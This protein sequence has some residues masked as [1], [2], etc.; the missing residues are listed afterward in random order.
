MRKLVPTFIPHRYR[1]A[2]RAV[3]FAV[4]S[5]LFVGSRYECP[6][7]GRGSRGWVSLGF[8][9]LVCPHC[10]AFERQRLLLL[11]L[12][13]ELEI[14]TRPLTMLHFAPERCLMRSFE[15]FP[16]LTYIGGDLDPPRGAVK[17]DIT[18]IELGSDTVDV[19]ICSHV[20]E[21]VSEDAQAMREMR[22]VLRPGGS[23]LIMGPVD[24]D[25]PQTYEDP[26]IVNPRARVAAF[27]QS[28]HV[29]LYGAD[30]DQ[31]LRA[32]GF[33]VDANR[34]AEQL[35]SDEVVRHG[36]DRHEIIYVCT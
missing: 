5:V 27:G 24:Y 8:P 1:N 30:F 14:A 11:Y 33:E 19:V 18:N 31:R 3:V 15:R 20:L 13:N 22:R 12:R 17:L 26:T 23:A 35:P 6:V 10:S 4:L 25:R 7:C 2:A 16:N 9:N 29:R 34:Y 21:H 36:L 28:D 32:A